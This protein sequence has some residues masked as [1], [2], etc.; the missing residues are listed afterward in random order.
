VNQQISTNSDVSVTLIAHQDGN[1]KLLMARVVAAKTEKLETQPVE[2]ALVIDR[3]G[4]MSGNKLVIVKQACA[5]LIRALSPKDRVAVVMYDN[6]V[7]IISALTIP[8]RALAATVERLEPGGNTNLY[9]GWLQGAKLLNPGGRIILLSDGLANSGQYTDAIS[10][11]HQASFT[12]EKFQKM[13]S[14]IGVGSDYDEAL[15]AGM[16]Q[17]GGGSHYF[18][19]NTDAIMRAFSEE[20][21][22]IDQMVLTE[23]RLLCNGREHWIGN[24]WGGEIKT[25]V[26]PNASLTGDAILQ[27]NV[28][29]TGR[30]GTLP[31]LLPDE[32][33]QDDEVTL[34]YLIQ[35]VTK[36]ESEMVQVRSR[37]TAR[38]MHERLRGVVLKLMN[39]PLS[40]KEKG[41]AVI[42]S[43]NGSLE[44][45]N[46][47]AHT[48]DERDA[49]LHRK[50][51]MQKHHNLSQRAKA[52]SSFDDGEDNPDVLFQMSRMAVPG[53][54]TI[55]PD[56]HGLRLAPIEQWVRWKAVPVEVRTHGVKIA[57]LNPKDGFLIREM[58]RDL[59]LPVEPIYHFFSKD[60]I[61]QALE[62]LAR[63]AV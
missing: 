8:S 54:E 42:N 2:I 23:V 52:Y 17:Q 22:S 1:Q 9:G 59:G 49:M 3:S 46:H 6:H 63:T 44:R 16:A 38:L 7:E 47:L 29:A 62:E 19:H 12:R 13:T 25:T 10:L 41:Q 45:L 40:D 31:L 27:Y 34:E 61:R 60:Q 36:L 5:R 48:Y 39:H 32:F 11:A 24:L 55:T 57:L 50:R 4:S 58:E 28:R 37:E 21:F 43:A 18:A 33:G 15:M 51:S 14:T 30:T 35:Q 20:Q 53:D 56:P 26:I